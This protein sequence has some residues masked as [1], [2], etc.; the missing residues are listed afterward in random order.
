MDECTAEE[1]N[2]CD[3][4]ALCSNTDG[5]YVCRCNEGYFGDGRNCTGKSELI[6]FCFFLRCA[7]VRAVPLRSCEYLTT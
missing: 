6:V 3:S 1:T 2:D 4:N 7:E 5:S